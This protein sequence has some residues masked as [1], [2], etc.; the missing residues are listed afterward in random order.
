MTDSGSRELQNFLQ[1]EDV[2]ASPL[3]SPGSPIPG[4]PE[5]R[6]TVSVTLPNTQRFTP[7]CPWVHMAIKLSGVL[8]ASEIISS[9]AKPYSAT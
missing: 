8:R 4:Q 2:I 5:W 7:E 1:V 6:T 9:A 3:M